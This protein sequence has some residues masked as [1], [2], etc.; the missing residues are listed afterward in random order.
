MKTVLTRKY[1]KNRLWKITTTLTPLYLKNKAFCAEY[2]FRFFKCYE[3]RDAIGEPFKF[4][5][6]KR[7]E[8]KTK[9]KI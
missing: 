8:V 1:Y 7:L 2:G 3:K 6:G 9:T 5:R 4:V